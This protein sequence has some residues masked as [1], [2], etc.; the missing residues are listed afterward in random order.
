[1]LQ[2][3]GLQRRTRLSD[4]TATVMRSLLEVNSSLAGVY[5]SKLSSCQRKLESIGMLMEER[6]GIQEQREGHMRA[7]GKQCE[8]P[9][10]LEGQ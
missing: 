7:P 9:R 1:M 5:L 10:S 6:A 8:W 2:S 3:V 4:R